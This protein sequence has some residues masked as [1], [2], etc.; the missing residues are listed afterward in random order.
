MAARRGRATP[1]PAPVPTSSSCRASEPGTS[2]I[3]VTDAEKRTRRIRVDVLAEG[4]LLI[5]AEDG[6]H[7]ATGALVDVRG[8]EQTYNLDAFHRDGS[9]KPFSAE[10][11]RCRAAP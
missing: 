2:Y 9:L 11:R 5:G 6:V 1:T 8:V 10:R 4:P 7:D 3:V